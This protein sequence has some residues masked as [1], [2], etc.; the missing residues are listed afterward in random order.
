MDIAY[1]ECLPLPR[2][3]PRDDETGQ[4]IKCLV[5]ELAS[6]DPCP[7]LVVSMLKRHVGVLF[8]QDVDRITS[9]MLKRRCDT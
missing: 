7:Q 5:N 3:F 2:E 1:R 4:L 8:A 9:E 6:S